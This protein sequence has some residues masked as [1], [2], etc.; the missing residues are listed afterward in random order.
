[1]DMLRRPVRPEFCIDVGSVMAQRREMLACHTSQREWLD[2]TQGG[3]LCGKYGRC[4][5]QVGRRYGGCNAEAGVGTAH[6]VAQPIMRRWRRVGPFLKQ[7]N[8]EMK[9]GTSDQ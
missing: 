6:G 8:K 1:M 5:A 7:S 4:G 3:V 9:D 2:A